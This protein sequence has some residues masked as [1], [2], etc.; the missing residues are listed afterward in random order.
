MV[1][2]SLVIDIVNNWWSLE[3]NVTKE[4][5]YGIEKTVILISNGPPKEENV[6]GI[7][8]IHSPNKSQVPVLD[9]NDV[10]AS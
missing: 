1:D 7:P 2:L 5:E 4:C 3:G 8:Q 9:H 6:L 10:F